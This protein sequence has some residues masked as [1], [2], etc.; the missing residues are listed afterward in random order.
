MFPTVS[1]A[2]R[3]NQLKT[4]HCCHSRPLTAT[5]ASA[6]ACPSRADPPSPF[7]AQGQ[8]RKMEG[9]WG[10]GGGLGKYWGMW[11]VEGC[12]GMWLG[13][14][15][16]TGGKRGKKGAEY[17]PF[18]SPISPGG[19]PVPIPGVLPHVHPPPLFTARGHA[20]SPGA[21]PTHGHTACGGRPALHH[22]REDPLPAAV[23]G[24]LAARGPR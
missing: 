6:D 23:A 21:P 14:G 20:P 9:N 2:R 11:G 17:P 18:H 1:S 12:G 3:T 10:T 5:A 4:G 22:L 16:T 13:G 8:M 19:R 7:T 24:R 15:G